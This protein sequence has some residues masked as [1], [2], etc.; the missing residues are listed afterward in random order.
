MVYICNKELF[1]KKCLAYSFLIFFG[2]G[3][4]SCFF[5]YQKLGFSQR[6]FKNILDLDFKTIRF[7]ENYILDNYKTDLVLKKEIY[8]NIF[9]FKS[10]KNYRGLRHFKGLPVRG[11]RTK[12]NARTCKR[13]TFLFSIVK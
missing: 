13:V 10:I 5:L 4:N 12:T 2:L 11:Q 8:N 1:F 7:L 3:L 9:L 6:K